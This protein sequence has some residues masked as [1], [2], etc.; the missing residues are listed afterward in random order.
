MTEFRLYPKSSILYSTLQP[1]IQL[2]PN[3]IQ[4][5]SIPFPLPLETMS[6]IY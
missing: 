2:D 4:I 6:I 5:Y 1:V 3:Y